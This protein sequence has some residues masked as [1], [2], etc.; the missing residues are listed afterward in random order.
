[1]PLGPGRAVRPA[2]RVVLDRLEHQQLGAVQV[3]DDRD[4]GR[5][6]RGGLVE[7]RQVV[8]VQ[9]VG[10]RRAGGLQRARPGR[11]LV[12]GVGVVERGEDAVGRVRA[13]LVG[14]VQRRVGGER[15]AAIAAR[16]VM[17]T[18]R[19]SRPRVEAARRRRGD[20]RA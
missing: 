20:R 12:L 15:V 7:R 18:G 2:V 16:A 4:A 19:T 17:S 10:V 6:A 3:A 9:D 14:R 1:M 13:V 5:D 11:D 8:Q